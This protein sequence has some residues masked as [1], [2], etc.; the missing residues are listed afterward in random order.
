MISWNVLGISVLFHITKKYTQYSHYVR[1][2]KKEEK[3]LWWHKLPSSP[4]P[5]LRRAIALLY[6]IYKYYWNSKTRVNIWRRIFYRINLIKKDFFRSM[7]FLAVLHT[8]ILNFFFCTFP[9]RNFYSSIVH[10]SS[11][12]IA[13][14][15]FL[16][17]ITYCWRVLSK[18]ASTIAATKMM[19]RFE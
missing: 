1:I 3:I 14:W 4:Y 10:S 5:L 11:L 7:H 17:W 9:K 16:V 15:L 18:V 8:S 19:F 12:F 6:C 13:I 2:I